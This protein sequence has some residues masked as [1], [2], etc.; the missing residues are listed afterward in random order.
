MQ[1][2]REGDAHLDAEQRLRPRVGS[3]LARQ[4][5]VAARQVPAQEA[6][7]RDSRPCA[8]EAGLDRQRLLELR[9]R[10]GEAAGVHQHLGEGVVRVRLL[11]R[12]GGVLAE[13]FGGLVE[14]LLPGVGVPEVVVGGSGVRIQLDRLAELGDRLLVILVSQGE[15]TELVVGAPIGRGELDELRLQL[16]RLGVLSAEAGGDHLDLRP[17]RLG[18]SSGA[19]QRQLD[20][21]PGLGRSGHRRQQGVR[22]RAGRVELDGLLQ[23]RGSFSEAH[24]VDERPGAGDLRDRRGRLARDR[25]LLWLPASLRSGL[26][27]RESWTGGGERERGRGDEDASHDVSPCEVFVP[28]AAAASQPHGLYEAGTDEF[29]AGAWPRADS[30]RRAGAFPFAG[31]RTEDGP[32]LVQLDRLD[33]VGIESGLP[34]S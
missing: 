1:K 4:R 8:G 24:V 7:L 31:E 21:L 12:D 22:G 25:N 28:G 9:F 5:I 19:G 23:R 17:L 20:V 3:L 27:E 16:A 18:Q 30:S 2:P 29:R 33:Q 6:R 14:L 15:P 34:S 11:G 32:Q 10:L 13:P 26:C